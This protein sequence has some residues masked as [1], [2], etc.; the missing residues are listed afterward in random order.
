MGTEENGI[1]FTFIAGLSILAFF[2]IAYG[3]SIAR[4]L[5]RRHQR[6]RQFALRDA[7]VVEMERKRIS[8][9]LH[10]DFGSTLAALRLGLEA[11]REQY[12]DNAIIDKTTKHLNQSAAKLRAISHNLLPKTVEVKGL[13]AGVALLVADFNESKQIN[14]QF[15]C[16]TN[17]SGFDTSNSIILYRVIQEMLTNTI[18]HA[19]AT[20][21]KISIVD[22]PNKLLLQYADNGKGF[23]VNKIEEKETKHGLRNICS[24]LEL[25]GASYELFTGQDKGVHYK[26]T[27]PIQSMKNTNGNG[28][29]QN[30]NSGRS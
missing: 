6:Y 23:T 7:H 18:K 2:M 28:T 15:I 5:K 17:D 11:I 13:A 22:S 21:V 9:D 8:E 20:I 27:I 14:I 26:I 12:P 4:N 29:D 19:E 24:R 25:L 1:Y 3:I 30:Y 10:D 16:D